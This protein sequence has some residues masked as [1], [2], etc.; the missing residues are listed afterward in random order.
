MP[1]SS[2]LGGIILPVKWLSFDVVRQDKNAL[3]NW[4]VASEEANH[5]YEVQRST[6]GIHFTTITSINKNVN[7]NHNYKYTDAGIINSGATILYYKIKQVDIDGKMSYSDVRFLRIEKTEQPYVTLYPVPAR[8]KLN[9]IIKS[10][11]AVKTELQILD[12]SGRIMSRTVAQVNKGNNNI[13]LQVNDLPG[14]QYMLV[15]SDA[16]LVINQ[17]FTVIR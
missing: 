7:G 9:V 2:T 8:D 16:S 4:V 10:D 5:H 6:D 14:G 3:L 15:S 17:K 11:I 1:S 13:V 12:M